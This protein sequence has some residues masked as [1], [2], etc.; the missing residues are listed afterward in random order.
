MLREMPNQK[1]DM[2]IEACQMRVRSFERDQHCYLSVEQIS[3]D[4]RMLQDA[5][6]SFADSVDNLKN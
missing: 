3:K 4:I 1:L 6:K 2:S 5:K